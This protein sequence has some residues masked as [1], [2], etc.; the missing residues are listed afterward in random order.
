MHQHAMQILVVIAT[1]IVLLE[2]VGVLQPFLRASTFADVTEEFVEQFD[3]R[4]FDV[5]GESSPSTMPL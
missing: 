3:D 5:T 1:L 4:S 2:F